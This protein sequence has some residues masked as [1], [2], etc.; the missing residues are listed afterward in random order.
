[1]TQAQTTSRAAVPGRA[2]GVHES[3]EVK[4]TS[5][6]L[7]MMQWAAILAVILLFH[8]IHKGEFLTPVITFIAGAHFISLAQRF[9]S[10]KHYVTGALLMAW[11]TLLA[12]MFPGELMPTVG[13]LGTAAIL[14]GSGAWTLASAG[15]S[16]G[17]R[18]R[19]NAGRIIS[20]KLIR[21]QGLGTR[22]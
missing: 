12:M 20:R 18:G 15:T 2:T 6:R 5:I 9:R 21:I 22:A 19:T 3:A 10:L 1:M 11:A 7:T 16:A 4:R 17:R 13:T 14:L 8:A